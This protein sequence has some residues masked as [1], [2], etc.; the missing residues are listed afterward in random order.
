MILCN[1]VDECNPL[2]FQAV[3]YVLFQLYIKDSVTPGAV[4]SSVN[5]PHMFTFDGL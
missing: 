3:S 1:K 5:D 4:C 2:L